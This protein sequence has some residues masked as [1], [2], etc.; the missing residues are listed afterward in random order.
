MVLAAFLVLLA[1]AAGAGDADSTPREEARQCAD[2]GAKVVGAPPS[3]FEDVCRGVRSALDFFGAHG[4]SR[5]APIQVE[6]TRKLAEGVSPTASGYY[7]ERTHV[8]YMVPYADFRRNKTWFGVPIDRAMYRTMAA[9]EAA[10]AIAASNFKAPRPTIEAKEYLAYVAAFAA[11]PPQ[12]RQRALR[13]TKTEGF[14]SLD[15]FTPLLYMFDPMR[16]GAEA[17][18]H[19][20]GAADPAALIAGI[21][22]G[23]LLAS[24]E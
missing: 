22:A 18:R 16:F 9:H 7:I 3:D 2:T 4:V 21:F 14:D 24:P 23:E 20:L 5:A 11:M 17:Y 15:R 1:L 13:A 10:H 19:F 8:I 12:L 6:I